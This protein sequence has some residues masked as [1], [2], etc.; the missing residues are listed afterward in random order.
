MLLESHPLASCRKG[1]PA[2]NSHPLASC[3]KGMPT[4]NS[5]APF[6]Q[7]AWRQNYAR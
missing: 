7:H 2:N 6:K 3:R 5:H 1:I 4:N